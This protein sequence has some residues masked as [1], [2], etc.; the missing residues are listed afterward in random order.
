M[1]LILYNT[2]IQIWNDECLYEAP[3][4]KL[5]NIDPSEDDYKD[6][7]NYKR[8]GCVTLSTVLIEGNIPNINIKN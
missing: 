5:Q 2:K 3:S 7:W 6:L 4:L 8:F 1:H